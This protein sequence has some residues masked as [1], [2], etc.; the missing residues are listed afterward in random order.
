MAAFFEASVTTMKCQPWRPPA[1]GACRATSMHSRTID[2]GTAR[3]RSS[4]RRTVRVVVSRRSTVAMSMRLADHQAG[5]DL[6]RLSQIFDRDVLVDGV[7]LL[8]ADGD[9]QALQPVLV[10]GVRVA[11]AAAHPQ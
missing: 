3:V 9:V 4:R 2:A 6:T 7:D 8:H 11:A 1:V 5:R 10:E